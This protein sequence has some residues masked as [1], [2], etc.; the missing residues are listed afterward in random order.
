MQQR[1][2]GPTGL[3]VSEFAL[4]TMTFGAESDEQQSR[5]QLDRYVEAGGTLIDTAD[6]YQRGESERIVGRWLSERRD[7]E[8]L[9]V[10]TKARMPMGDG[11]NQRGL[12][13][14]WLHRA[15]D[16]SLTRLQVAHI[17][18]YQAHCWDPA[19]PIEETLE[20]LDELVTAG[21]VRYVGV[22]NF[23]GW[24]LQRAVLVARYEGRPPIVSLQ[25]QYNLLDRHIEWE[26]L[27]LCEDEGLGVLPWSPLGGGWLTGKYRRDEGPTGATRLGEDPQRGVEAWDARNTPRTWALLE[28]LRDVAQAHGTSMSRVALRWVTDR[29]AVASTIL[30]ARTVDQLDDNL[31]ASELILDA[32]AVAELD[33][34]SDP[35][36]PQYPYGFIE[37]MS[38]DRLA[39]ARS[40]R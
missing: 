6:V 28:A 12:S 3:A 22:S 36:R 20:A 18:L 11:P 26:L 23:T 8:D 31:A 24:Q 13:K 19:T 37:D 16:A 32:D 33:R 1:L 15:V 5:A 39:L 38:A 30:G 40:S 2:L 35:G 9:V 17:D 25:P 7:R 29:P 10:A 21:K 34:H 27:P 4:G 14:A